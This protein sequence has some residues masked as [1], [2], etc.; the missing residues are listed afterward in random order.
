MMK[1]VSVVDLTFAGYTAH[2]CWV[3]KFLELE[4]KTLFTG[5]DIR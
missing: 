4:A 3:K 5:R 1:N 2:L